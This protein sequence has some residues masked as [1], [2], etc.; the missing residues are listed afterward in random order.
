MYVL[1]DYE[2]VVSFWYNKQSQSQSLV[3]ANFITCL[4]PEMPINPRESAKVTGVVNK[5]YNFSAFTHAQNF[6]VESWW[7]YQIDLSKSTKQNIVVILQAQHKNLNMVLGWLEA[8]Q[9]QSMMSILATRSHQCTTGNSFNL[10]RLAKLFS[11]F[12]PCPSLWSVATYDRKLSVSM[13]KY[14]LR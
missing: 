5:V 2:I 8:F 14:I 9:L 11:S 7:T 12:S 1:Y 6:A 4:P 10:H 3:L 13:P